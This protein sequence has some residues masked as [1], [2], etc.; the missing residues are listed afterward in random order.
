MDLHFLRADD[1][2][3]AFCFHAAH[4]GVGLRSGVTHP[5]AVRDLVEAVLGDYGTDLD[6]FKQ[7]V[8][9]GITGHCVTLRLLEFYYWQGFS[10][11]AGALRIPSTRGSRGRRGDASRAP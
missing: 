5:I 11:G 3:T 4:G 2:P 8:E 9:A 6:G 10:E 1:R 7:N